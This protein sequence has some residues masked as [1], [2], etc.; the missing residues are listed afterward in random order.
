M[1]LDWVS[2]NWFFLD[3]SYD[4]LFVCNNG[5]TICY[6]ILKGGLEKPRD[7][8]VDPAYGYVIYI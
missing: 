5:M 3:D 7:L 1:A 8:A 2:G 4:R 6:D